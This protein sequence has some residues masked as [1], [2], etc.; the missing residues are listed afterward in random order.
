M[1][2]AS[3]WSAV[4]EP[5]ATVAEHEGWDIGSAGASI[6]NA[7]PDKFVGRIVRVL[8]RYTDRSGDALPFA[9]R[10]GEAGNEVQ[11]RLGCLGKSTRKAVDLF[12]AAQRG[13]VN[14]VR[15]LLPP[16]GDPVVDGPPDAPGHLMDLDQPL[17]HAA[18]QIGVRQSQRDTEFTR[19]VALRHI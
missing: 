10:H 15:A 1:S 17:A 12:A 3:P 7:E 13:E 8:H 6:A 2:C 4:A 11:V 19:N 16:Y 5:V 18:T 9:N 14:Q